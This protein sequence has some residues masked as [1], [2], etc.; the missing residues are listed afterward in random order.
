MKLKSI[1]IV[2]L[3]LIIS[4]LSYATFLLQSTNSRLQDQLETALGYRKQLQKQSELNIRNRLD[5]ESQ[6]ESLEG[7]LL[8]S[9]SQLSS[10]SSELAEAKLKANPDY[11]ALME[12]ARR[13]VI[14]ENGRL[15]ERG[16]PSGGFSVFS[17]PASTRKMAEDKVAGQYLSYFETLAL[18]STE[19]DSMY[20]AFVDFSDERYQ[21]LGQLIAGNL[22]ADQAAVMFGPNALVDNLKDNLT[23]KQAAELGAYDL[24]M[25]QDAFRQ[26]YTGIF[27]QVSDAISG[28]IQD[29]VMDV[30][31]DE[32]FSEENNYGALVADN[33]SMT[34]AYIDKLDSFGR[35]RERLEPN[36]TAEQLF[37]FD[38]FAEGQFG[39]VDVV[40][41]A[42]TDGE[43]KVQMR[44]MRLSAESLPN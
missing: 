23:S 5:F 3:S 22:T 12:Q 26:V 39:T 34:S 28:Q 15:V 13:E 27:G 31:I 1:L 37:Q 35:A 10:L 2:A 42:N 21:M 29:Y 14:T 40:L 38:R 20:E 32:V 4:G 6:L 30:V 44:N 9:S 7:E 24:M 25:N 19:M 16:R 36:L 17:D 41:E 11:E 18:S 8:A 33:G 43:G